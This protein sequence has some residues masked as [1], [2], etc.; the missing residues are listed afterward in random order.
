MPEAPNAFAR[1]EG[2][3]GEFIEYVKRLP[4]T[5]GRQKPGSMDQDSYIAIGGQKTVSRKHA[6][7]DYDPVA[8]HF[9]IDI[10]GKNG[11]QIGKMNFK[12]ESCSRGAL[13]LP[14]KTPMR[15]GVQKFY[16]CPALPA[17]ASQPSKAAGPARKAPRK[18]SPRGADP[19]PPN[20][21]AFA[22]PAPAAPAKPPVPAPAP[23]PSTEAAGPTAPNAPRAGAQGPSTQAKQ[24]PA[25]P[26]SKAAESTSTPND[27]VPRKSHTAAKSTG[28]P[29]GT[30]VDFAAQV[31]L[32]DGPDAKHSVAEVMN[33][34]EKRFPYFSELKQDPSRADEWKKMRNNIRAS[35]KS[36]K[37]FASV[38]E[39]SKIFFRYVGGWAPGGKR[40]RSPSPSE[41]NGPS[42]PKKSS[43]S[44][45][46]V[47]GVAATAGAEGGARL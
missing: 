9:T 18:A 10:L 45:S 8:K 1:L 29:A 4:T 16:F 2:I 42:P 39:G 6:T 12:P 36:S 21:S 14:P 46:P 33:M 34:I 24:A 28:K 38:K 44:S 41:G 20:Q 43:R 27:A 25:N 17:G 13:K 30:S 40:K 15:I 5:L 47:E 35:M 3:N 31:M 22:A 32:N 7:I 26:I 19:G 23:A 11:V 37:M